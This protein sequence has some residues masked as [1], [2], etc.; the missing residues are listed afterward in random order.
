[1]KQNQTETPD[2]TQ[3]VPKSPDQPHRPGPT[4]NKPERDVDLPNKES[5]NPRDNK[6]IKGK[7][8]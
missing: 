6:D 8:D 3:P 2:T 5:E 7:N 4:P 1:M